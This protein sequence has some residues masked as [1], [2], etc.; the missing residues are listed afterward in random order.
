MPS[1]DAWS[2]WI[3]IYGAVVATLVLVWDVAKW[4]RQGPRIRWSVTPNMRVIGDPTRSENELFVSIVATNIGDR[5]TTISNLGGEW[6]RTWRARL[7]RRSYQGF[8]VNS[9]SVAHPLPHLLQPGAVWQGLVSQEGIA[10]RPGR[11][12]LF[13]N[14]Y[15]SHRERPISRRLRLPPQ[16]HVQGTK[17]Q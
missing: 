14:L 17:S 12:A 2:F 3:A 7:R 9:P 8:V 5:A 11:G 10:D 4:T 13:M 16:A 15:V 1:L 6:Y